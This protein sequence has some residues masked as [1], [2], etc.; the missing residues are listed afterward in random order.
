MAVTESYADRV[1]NRGH[2]L[3]DPEAIAP[4]FKY[5]HRLRA[6]IHDCD[7]AAFRLD[8]AGV[9]AGAALTLRGNCLDQ[10]AASVVNQ[11]LV[12]GSV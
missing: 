3:L 10:C 6:E 9:A 2:Q 5:R 8:S 1:G 11:E 7:Q 4:A 12:R